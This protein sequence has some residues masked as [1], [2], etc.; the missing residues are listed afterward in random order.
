MLRNARNDVIDK[1]KNKLR[2]LSPYLPV[3]LNY[4]KHGF[5]P[6]I[7]VSAATSLT[8]VTIVW[9]VCGGISIFSTFLGLC[10]GF[11]CPF[12]W[13]AN[14]YQE[15]HTGI[16]R[17]LPDMIDMIALSMDAGL[18]FNR[19]LKT[20]VFFWQD[21]MP[22]RPII[23]ETSRIISL[24]DMGAIQN[25]QLFEIARNLVHPQT[26]RFFSSTAKNLRLG[27]PMAEAL[28]EEAAMLRF[29]LAQ[30]LERLAQEAPVKMLFPLVIF[31]FPAIFIIL[32]GPLFL[33][34]KLRGF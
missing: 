7:A 1:W 23:V 18:D 4:E 31:I 17:D 25:Q 19:A 15:Y 30:D 8:G 28:K 33:Q 11:I 9:I 12:V 22:L 29:T 32:L 20:Y 6:V 10:A 3:W 16:T 34:L 24:I 2:L 21:I 13:L 26:Y 27:T 14:R 5:K